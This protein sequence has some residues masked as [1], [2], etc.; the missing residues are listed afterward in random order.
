M[1]QPT[2][3]HATFVVQKSYSKPVDR[4][5]AAFSDAGKK[6][7]WYAERAGNSVETF[8]M[9]FR[10]GGSEVLAYRMGAASPMPG[11]LITNQEIF[12][13]IV[14]GKRIVTAS[15]MSFEGTCFSASL[16]TFEFLQSA[17]GTDLI[18]THQNAFFENSDGPERR[19][20]GWQDL[21]ARLDQEIMR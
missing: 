1:A 9:D 16:V 8:E 21:L 3:I 5:F 2:V 20:K 18:C 19:E 6:R 11:A 7:R 12:L 17:G 15:A 4:V 10:A 14:E 13:D